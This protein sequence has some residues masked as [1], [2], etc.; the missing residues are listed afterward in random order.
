MRNP[1]PSTTVKMWIVKRIL[2]IDQV[3]IEANRFDAIALGA[4]AIA[5]R[6]EHAAAIGIELSPIRVGVDGRVQAGD[7]AFVLLQAG[8]RHGSDMQSPRVVAVGS[9][10]DG[11]IG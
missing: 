1:Q 7:G 10:C 2:S 4:A 6:L 5:E 8:Q 3:R 9:Q 11:A